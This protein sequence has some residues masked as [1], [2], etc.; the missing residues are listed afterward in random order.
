LLGVAQQATACKCAQDPEAPPEGSE[1]AVVADLEGSTVVFAGRVTGMQR[2]IRLF[3]GI[4]RYRFLT[5]GDRE[6][7][8]EEEDRIFSRRVRLKVEE[9]FKGTASREVV[10]YTGWGGGDCGYEFRRGSRYLVY[11][12]GSGDWLYTGICRATKGIEKAAGEIAILREVAQ[13]ASPGAGDLRKARRKPA[14]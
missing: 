5:R 7:T 4:T 2:R 1:A 9:A 6:L 3:L 14:T 10:L 12:N 11:A 13:P 8:E